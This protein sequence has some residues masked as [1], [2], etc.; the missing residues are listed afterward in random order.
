MVMF[1]YS[2]HIDHPKFFTAPPIMN[3]LDPPVFLFLRYAIRKSFIEVGVICWENFLDSSQDK[4][5]DSFTSSQSEIFLFPAK[6]A[7][8][9][10]LCIY[11]IWIQYD[12]KFNSN[13]QKGVRKMFSEYTGVFFPSKPFTVLFWFTSIKTHS[14]YS[15]RRSG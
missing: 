4:R 1:I 5:S 2:I 11:T 8:V 7:K 6:N 12:Y 9:R 10:E 14:K 3:F 15:Y 13:N